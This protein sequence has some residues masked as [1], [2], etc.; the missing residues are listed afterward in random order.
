MEQSTG[1]NNGDQPII[2]QHKNESNG[3][4]TAGFILSIIA[5][6]AGCLPV[7]GWLVWLLGLIFSFIGIFKR[8]RGLAIAGLIISL[9][10]III[11]IF[12]FG[13]LAILGIASEG[14]EG[15]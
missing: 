5:L 4:G 10:G 12:I 15:M 3:I 1:Q 9:I 7:V 13:G 2:I 14:F 8:P 11:L 6:V